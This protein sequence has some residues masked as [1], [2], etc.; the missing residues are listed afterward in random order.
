M[1]GR[2]LRQKAAES[3]KSP[4]QSPGCGDRK[5]FGIQCEQVD[6]VS[7]AY[8]DMH[9]DPYLILLKSMETFPPVSP[10]VN[11]VDEDRIRSVIA[12]KNAGVDAAK[13]KAI[14]KE[15]K[16]SHPTL[17]PLVLWLIF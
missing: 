2:K 15:F 17:L 1:L 5:N 12:E 7:T 14:M 6:E 11:P 9:R 16:T 13:E 4:A 10:P 8:A 3:E